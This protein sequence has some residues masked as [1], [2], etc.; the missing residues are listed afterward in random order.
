M[1]ETPQAKAPTSKVITG[2]RTFGFLLLIALIMLGALELG[3]RMLSS[4]QRNPALH[5]LTQDY[6]RL[7]SH[8]PDWIR[9]VPDAELSYALRPHFT[10]DARNGTGQTRHNGAGFR[11][12]GEFGPKEKHTLRILCFGGSTTY[13]VG[14]AE[15][16]HT[17]P[18]QLEAFLSG[19]A[20]EA[21]WDSVEVFNLGVG[22]YT[23]REILGTMARTV[24][25]YEPDV[26]LIQNAINDVIPRFYPNFAADYS[27]FRTPFAALDTGSWRRLAYRS[28]LWLTV[29]QRAGW[30]KPLSLQSQT[31]RPMPSVDEA[32][33][34]LDQN[35]TSAFA[36]NL[37]AMIALAQEADAQVWLLTQPYFDSPQFAA[38]DAASRRLE[39][40]YR[41]GL[42]EHTAVV[43]E[44]ARELS[45]GLVP[46]HNDM[47]R[48]GTLFTDPIHMS[49]T[50]NAIKAEL[51][52]QRLTPSLPKPDR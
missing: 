20:R 51:V 44:L 29:A 48:R 16:R 34:H 6:S 19:P 28:H 22:G 7:L 32:L 9:F 31:Q 10:L 18:A 21:G 39:G 3:A 27:H 25:A 4:P 12:P 42:L 30:V 43:E 5:R 46:L 33:N 15:D 24:P 1:S 14:V 13:G 49:A 47:P 11:G 37:R 35:P 2:L 26:V 36:G 50:G 38:P 45:V 40:G 52:G 23:S 17:Y 41:K 8:G